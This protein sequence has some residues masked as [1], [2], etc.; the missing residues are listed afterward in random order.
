MP[1]P[2]FLTNLI[3]VGSHFFAVL[4]SHAHTEVLVHYD[5][6][7]QHLPESN[8]ELCVCLCPHRYQ[9]RLLLAAI[10][11]Q[12]F[13]R[14]RKQKCSYSRNRYPTATDNT[15]QHRSAS[16]TELRVCLCPHRYLTR[17]PLA[18]IFLQS[19]RRMRMQRSSYTSTTSNSNR[20]HRAAY[21]SI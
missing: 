18:S 16:N 3:I 1:M 7:M 13:W 8:S 2:I 20:Q 5:N 11:L 12:C 14:M 4:Q 19:F 10:S 9:P 15:M 6:T 21:S 17:L